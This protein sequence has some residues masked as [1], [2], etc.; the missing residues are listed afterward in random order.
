MFIHV[1][2]DAEN[3]E[4]A[5]VMAFIRCHE[6]SEMS[7]K[8]S[9]KGLQNNPNRRVTKE[10]KKDMESATFEM[11]GTTWQFL[12]RFQGRQKINET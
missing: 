12:F 1:K 11:L 8:K 6:D 9:Q 4:N 7:T 2:M 3:N 10:T 5:P